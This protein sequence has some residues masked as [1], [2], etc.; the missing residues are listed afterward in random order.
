MG[1]AVKRAGCDWY[2]GVSRILMEMNITKK[3]PTGFL[4]F[5]LMH[6][7]KFRMNTKEKDDALD[8]VI[9]TMDAADQSA[10]SAFDDACVR[11]VERF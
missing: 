4:P 3:R 9:E 1:F 11:M 10:E 7:W 8:N 2:V 5:E 6:T